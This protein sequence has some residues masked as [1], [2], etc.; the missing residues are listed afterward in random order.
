MAGQLNGE[1][2]GEPAGILHQDRLSTVGVDIGQQFGETWTLVD[3][4]GSA[5][6]GVV[7]LPG[8]GE[9]VVL[10][11]AGNRLSLAL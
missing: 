11:V 3:G 5:H 1:V 6:C 2:T 7:K 9:P 10:G 8:Q 4:V